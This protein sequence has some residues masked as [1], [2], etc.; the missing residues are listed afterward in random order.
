MR[1]TNAVAFLL[2]A[3]DLRVAIGFAPV[4]CTLIVYGVAV[5]LPPG[6][7]ALCPRHAVS[8]SELCTPRYHGD[9]GVFPAKAAHRFEQCL[10]NSIAA[11]FVDRPA[12]RQTP[13]S[14]ALY[15]CRHLHHWAIPAQRMDVAGRR[16]SF[17]FNTVRNL[18]S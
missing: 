8:G 18:Q 10:L 12:F 7:P 5:R 16:C 6:E 9:I 4:A 17:S 15:I 14:G 11:I 2:R 13:P 1:L 3:V